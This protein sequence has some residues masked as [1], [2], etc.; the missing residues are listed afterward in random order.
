MYISKLELR[1]FRNYDHLSLDLS[2]GVNVIYGKNGY[3][4][5]NLLEAM[6]LC[7][8]GKSFKGA[9]DSEIIRYNQNE[10]F[11]KTRIEENTCGTISVRYEKNKLKYVEIDGIYIEKLRFLL[12]RIIGIMFSPESIRIVS[13]GPSQR[14]K[15]LDIALC[16]LSTDY[17]YSLLMYN[18]FC[19]EK[20]RLLE[21]KAAADEIEK[22]VI[23]ENL[24][25]YGAKIAYERM[26][27]INEMNG[28]AAGKYGFIS[29]EEEKL[30]VE[31]V[32]DIPSFVSAANALIAGEKNVPRGTISETVAEM[33]EEKIRELFLEDLSNKKLQQ[34]EED[35]RKNLI[36][37]QRDDFDILFNGMSMRSFGSQGQ[38]RSAAIALTFAVLEIMKNRSGRVPILFFDDVLSELDKGRKNKI[39]ILSK[40]VQTI[41]TCTERN[42]LPAGA[43]NKSANF[44]NVEKL[45]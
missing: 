17:Y 30:A 40:E 8:I 32:P 37:V 16:Q 41:F 39:A 26:R 4:K 28:A 5:T 31:Y 34:R 38:K 29:S 42:M 44:I 2:P 45:R 19:E 15:F 23:N 3:G 12:G 18:R 6:F 13:E 21:S 9:K 1:D 14:R 36:G 43:G 10:Y 25:K 33:T 22:T 24:A 11:V 20:N 27:F 35:Y 7:C